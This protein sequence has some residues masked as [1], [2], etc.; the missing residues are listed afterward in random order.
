[1]L[2][3][4][5]TIWTYLVLSVFL[6]IASHILDCIASLSIVAIS[7]KRLTLK[8]RLDSLK[9]Q[10]NRTSEMKLISVIILMGVLD[11]V[12]C[13]KTLDVKFVNERFD[14]LETVGTLLVEHGKLK[15]RFKMLEYLTGV[16]ADDDEVG[17]S[18]EK[19]DESLKE[20]DDD[21]SIE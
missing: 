3:K 11:W 12:N 9:Q 17:D 15:E 6:Y 20:D 19:V 8:C 16:S 1:M 13:E 21:D 18:Y 4:S 5:V 7:R 14:I 10:K 2:S